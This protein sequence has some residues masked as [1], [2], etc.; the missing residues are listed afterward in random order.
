MAKGF[1]SWILH[2]KSEETWRDGLGELFA[3]KKLAKARVKRVRILLRDIFTIYYDKPLTMYCGHTKYS[4]D[5]IP[6]EFYGRIYRKTTM[7]EHATEENL[8]EIKLVSPP[9]LEGFAIRFSDTLTSTQRELMIHIFHQ[10]DFQ[11]TSNF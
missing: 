2:G 1:S 11:I 10:K 9:T 6:L 7:G 4:D 5:H 8:M 3:D